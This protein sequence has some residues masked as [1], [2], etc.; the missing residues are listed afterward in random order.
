M[1]IL[2]IDDE[3]SMR[4]IIK[5]Y[6]KKLESCELYEASSKDESIKILNSGTIDIA[7]IDIR[8]SQDTRNRDGQDIIQYI[9]KNALAIPIIISSL[10]SVD[11]IKRAMKNGAHDYILKETLS[12]EVLLPIIQNLCHGIRNRV[13]KQ[14]INM[15]KQR[16]K[17][18][19][20]KNQ[21]LGVSKKAVRIRA[22][23]ERF[24]FSDRPVLITGPTGSG[25]EVVAS[26]LHTFSEYPEEP[27]LTIN[28]GAFP[29][30]LIESLLFGHK[31]GAF[32]GATESRDGYLQSVKNGTLFLDEIGELPLELQPKLLR[33]LEN[34]KYTPIGETTERTFYGRIVA[35]THQDLKKAASNKSFREDLY[36]RLNVLRI[37]VPSLNERREDIPLFISKFIKD[38]P[39]KINFSTGAINLM[40]NAQWE[41]NVRQLRNIIDRITILYDAPVISEEVVRD[42]LSEDSISTENISTEFIDQLI[43]SN[44]LHKNKL[45]AMEM[46]MINHVLK[47]SNGNK[48]AAAKLLGI[49]RKLLARRLGSTPIT[50]GNSK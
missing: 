13:L 40:M 33:V 25:K 29:P 20:I 46:L 7:L 24:S 22:L 23:I 42:I 39:R 2:I 28:C 31:K 9:S 15:Y 32:T 35:A 17:G 38:Q 21:F 6:L 19:F 5:K 36:F 48:S 30:S 26:Q 4:H 45:H 34:R 10:S 12:P 27:M 8:L 49:D 50:S 14:Q 1:N 11:E 47:S 16:E 18:E 3:R 43:N 37:E 44:V 41:G